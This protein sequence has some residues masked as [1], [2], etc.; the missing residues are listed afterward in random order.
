MDVVRQRIREMN[1]SLELHTRPGAG[2]TFSL[3]LPLTLAIV[4]ALT[5]DCAGQRFAVPVAS[6]EEV[7]EIEP[8]DVVRSEG[9]EMLHH[10]GEVL[11]VLRLRD[12]LG[13]AEAA[14]E[15]ERRH[16]LIAD[17]GG[18]RWAIGVDRLVGQQGVVVKPLGDEL[19]RT[20]GVVGAT[21]LG[22][23]ELVLVLDVPEL[24]RAR[25]E[26]RLVAAGPGRRDG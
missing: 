5:A 7:A 19:V 14:P 11:P 16:A 25:R 6:V 8:A 20:P 22:D 13:L 1:G 24:V 3:R 12:A 26:R 9:S 2:S 23:G 18:T 4:E 21:D 15:R 17:V 10:R